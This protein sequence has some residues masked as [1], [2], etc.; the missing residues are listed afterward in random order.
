MAVSLVVFV[1]NL[2]WR[3][4]GMHNLWLGFDDRM[5]KVLFWFDEIAVCL[6]FVGCVCPECHSW[7]LQFLFPVLHDFL[8][9]LC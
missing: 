9:S 8:E 5:H 3:I 7:K 2:G 4:L 1:R 6:N